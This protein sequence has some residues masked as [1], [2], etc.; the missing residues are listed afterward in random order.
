MVALYDMNHGCNRFQISFY[1]CNKQSQYRKLRISTTPKY[2]L[3]CRLY[4]KID[5]VIYFGKSISFL[6]SV[7]APVSRIIGIIVSLIFKLILGALVLAVP[8]G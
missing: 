6:I 2:M 7:D 8:F 1:I 4:I 3:G 5:Y